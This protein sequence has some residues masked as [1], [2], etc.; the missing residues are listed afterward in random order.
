MLS[1]TRRAL[2]DFDNQHD[3]ERMSADILNALGYLNVEPMAP[4]GGS[5]GGQDI[6][7]REGDSPGIA[8]VTLQKTIRSKFNKDL[9]KQDNDG[10]VIALFCNVDITPAMKLEFVKGALDKKYRLEVFDLERI[11]SLLDSSLRDIRRRYLK[12]DDEI[13]A[14]L[15]SEV[16]KLLRYPAAIPITS[17][18]PTIIERMLVN[19]LPCRLFDLLMDYEENDI[20]EVPEI[21]TDL[22]KHL[23]AY[24]QFREESLQLENQLVSKI[25]EQVICRFR[26]AWEIYF[27]YM[28]MRLSGHSKETI[29]AGGNFLNYGITWDDAERLF[30]MLS[31]DE[32][33]SLAVSQL[34]VMHESLIQ[35]LD[36]VRSQISCRLS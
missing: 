24:Y 21:G 14:K 6:K 18:P 35:G 28:L 9:A 13:A 17:V 27:R 11:R 7:F 31:S 4:G 20:I 1:Q 3:F 2:E 34:F 36:V 8:F 26:E 22:F 23:T 16:Y 5:D 25:G 10:G 12:I 32:A 30:T 29:V 33:I 15:R 19:T